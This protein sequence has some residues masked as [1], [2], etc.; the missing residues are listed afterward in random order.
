MEN[1]K[2]NPEKITEKDIKRSSKRW[3]MASQITWNYE[4]MMG[5]G[6]LYAML[7]ILKKLY[8]NPDDLKDMM[9]NHAQF[10]N[11][12]PHMGGFIVGIDIAAEEAEGKDCKETVKGIKTGLM[13]PFAGVGDTIFGVLIPTICGSIAGY[14]GQNGNV[15]GV[16]IWI[17]VNIAILIF[18]YFTMGMGYKGGTKLIASTKNKLDALTHAAI[19]LGLTVVGAL[20]PTVVRANVT[21]N[22]MSGDVTLAGQ[23]ILNQIM[24]SLVPVLVVVGIYALLGKKK[25]TSTK[26]ILLVMAASIVFY[27]IG[28]L[29]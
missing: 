23:D 10:F 29:G 21:A 4:K 24:P 26:A 17:L 19:L 15:A 12:T 2:I 22:F 8:Q 25:M 6:Y 9:K 28:F 7:P 5:I 27:A 11:T 1:L 18:R 13:G 14:M 16:I 20:I 3:I